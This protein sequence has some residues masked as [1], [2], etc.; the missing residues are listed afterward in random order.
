M[1][2]KEIVNFRNIAYIGASII[3]LAMIVSVVIILGNISLLA[4]PM[5]AYWFGFTA[6]AFAV[7]TMKIF[8][9]IMRVAE[10]KFEE[11]SEDE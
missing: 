11:I 3:M 2:E 6:C 10:L 7:V 4:G 1:S 5:L 9:E 8:Y